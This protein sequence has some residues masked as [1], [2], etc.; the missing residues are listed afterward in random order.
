MSFIAILGAGAL[1]G[2]VAWRLA[3]RDRIREVR[4][5]DPD[6]H[7][8]RGKALDILQSAP[9]EPFSTRV[10]ADHRLAAVA[11]AR[12]IVLADA[13]DGTGDYAGEA[14]LALMRRIEALE[15]ETPIV[16]AGAGQRQLIERSVAELHV[17]PHR[18]VGSAPSALES[19]VRA[20]AAL[21]VNGAGRDVQ[22]LVLGAPPDDAIIAWEEATVFGQPIGALVPPHRLLALSARVPALWPPGPQALASAAARMVEAIVNGSRRRFTGFASMDQASG[23][24]SVVA[25]P[26]E[27]GARGVIRVVSPVLSRQE[28]TAF[29]SARAD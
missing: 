4:L 18:V 2:S 23:K 25:V 6:E 10:T 1:G 14:G 12:A 22:L 26:I 28:Q 19:A 15:T 3:A 20:L 21:E 29:D 13:A 24:G 11:G 16:C 8:A 7:I 9:F 5:I 27:L 17:A